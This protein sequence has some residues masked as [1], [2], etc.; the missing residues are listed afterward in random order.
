VHKAEENWFWRRATP[1]LSLDVIQPFFDLMGLQ[2]ADIAE[3]Q[4]LLRQR[5]VALR[6]A[7]L[8]GVTP[9]DPDGWVADLDARLQAIFGAAFVENFRKW[10]HSV[11]L[12]PGDMPYNA[13]RL[14]FSDAARTADKWQSLGFERQHAE[15][16]RQR[17]LALSDFRSIQALM[18]SVKSQKLSEWDTAIYALY[19]FYEDLNDPVDDVVAAAKRQRL[20]TFWRE[21]EQLTTA[22]ERNELLLKAQ[23]VAKQ[24]G[25]TLMLR[26]LDSKEWATW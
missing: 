21:I 19:N 16:L 25:M 26:L 14:L 22:E 8:S 3:F 23:V 9:P 18:K 13:W 20:F 7:K 5:L 15:T 11:L 2:V 12:P 10:L 4:I 17:Y 24:K 6:P 1:V